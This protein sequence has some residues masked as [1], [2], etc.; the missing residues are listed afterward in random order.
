MHHKHH[1]RPETTPYDKHRQ[2]TG[3][4]RGEP[5]HPGNSS[6]DRLRGIKGVKRQRRNGQHHH[7]CHHKQYH[8]KRSPNDE[9]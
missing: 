8:L 3:N 1:H 9:Q 5:I 2:Q 4:E 6:N 7:E